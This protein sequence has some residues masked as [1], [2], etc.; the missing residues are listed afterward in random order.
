MFASCAFGCA[1]GGFTTRTCFFISFEK[2]ELLI[3]PII[4]VIPKIIKTRI[5]KIFVSIPALSEIPANIECFED[6]FVGVTGSIVGVRVGAFFILVG[7]AVAACVGDKDTVGIAVAE[8]V[9]VGPEPVEGV[10]VG[11]GVGEGNKLFC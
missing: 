10:I 6:G 11:L 1:A 5:S 3:K 7:V 4:R 8:G 2:R 9:A